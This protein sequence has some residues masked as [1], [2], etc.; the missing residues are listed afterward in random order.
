MSNSILN[1]ARVRKRALYFGS[2]REWKPTRVS[3]EF[4]NRF[5]A[6]ADTLL[7]NMIATLPSKGKTIK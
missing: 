3:E 7:R 6:A 1:K 2:L 5:E 4:M